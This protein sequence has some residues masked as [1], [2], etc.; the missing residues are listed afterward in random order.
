MTFSSVTVLVLLLAVA[1]DVT[2]LIVKAAVRNGVR[3]AR[4]GKKPPA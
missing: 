3:E 1:A 4:D 2:Y